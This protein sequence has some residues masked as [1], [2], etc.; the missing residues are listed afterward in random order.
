VS[1]EDVFGIE[2][3]ELTEVSGPTDNRDLILTVRYDNG[4]QSFPWG[5]PETAQEVQY[6]DFVGHD[7]YSRSGLAMTKGTGLWWWLHSGPGS[8]RSS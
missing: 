4:T 2:H 6:G 5:I 7:N 3:G 1:L 8:R